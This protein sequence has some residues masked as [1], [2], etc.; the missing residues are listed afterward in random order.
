MEATPLSPSVYL[1]ELPAGNGKQQDPSREDDDLVLP[2]ISR[3][4]M[5]DDIADK[6]P[7]GYDPDHPALL[8]VQQPFAEILDISQ[9]LAT[10][11]AAAETINGSL[12]SLLPTDDE[13]RSCMDAVTMSFFKG[14][15]EANKLLPTIPNRDS[16]SSDG[17][18]RKKRHGDGDDEAEAGNMNMGS[19]QMAPPLQPDESDE[20]EAAARGMLERLMLNGGHDDPNSSRCRLADTGTAKEKETHT[21]PPPPPRR[22]R[23]SSAGTNSKRAAAVD[24]HGLLVRCAEA[25]AVNDRSGTCDLLERIKRHSSATGDGTQR[26][27]H[28]FATAL[29]ARLA[30][31]GA[32]VYRS[33]VARRASAASVVKAYQLYMTSCCFVPV[34]QLFCHAT[35]CGAVAGRKKLHIVHYGLGRGLQWPE[36][37]RRLARREGGPPE[38][39]LTGI[40]DPLPG[41]RP[42]QRVV[43]TGRLLSGCARQFGVPFEFHGIAAS[44]EAVHVQDL[45]IDPDEVLVVVSMLHLEKLMDESVV[46]E[47]PNPRDV[48]LGTIRKMRPSVFI[49]AVSSRSLSSAFFLTR[50]R[51]ALHSYTALFD[52]MDAVAGRGSDRRL[53]MEREIFAR[54]VT[55][56]VACEGADRV[57]RPQSYRQWQARS[58]RAGLRQLPLDPGIVQMIKGKV[59]KE[60]HMDFVIF[61]DHRWLL[62]GWKGRV[63]YALSTWTVDDDR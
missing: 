25:V 59:S 15:D 8:N 33:L 36:L 18:S 43:E 16:E 62:Q 51:E 44:S 26:L 50:F 23:R 40:D 14:M 20:E 46:V 32:Q 52:M 7:Y 63:L 4:L 54:C 48:V 37:L 22:R 30:G 19:K 9:P 6:L 41:F 60:F 27:A 3:M 56:V 34:N 10:D 38:V 42:A 12:M 5:E 11:T 57:E 21:M 13:S 17:G 1:D 2:Y 53:V 55:N 58:H 31:T 45:L 24:L 47:R 39:R 28:C 49:H 29:E 61:E 35:I